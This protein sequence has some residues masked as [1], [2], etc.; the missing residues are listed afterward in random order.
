MTTEY[1]ETRMIN[2][3]LLQPYPGNAR[4]GDRKVLLESLEANGQYRSLVVRDDRDGS[5]DLIVL[6]GN[7]TLAALE[8]RGDL[9]AR[10]EIITCDDATAL[11]VNLVDNASNDKAS[12]DDRA[13]AQLIDLL[14]GGISGSGYDEDEADSILARFEE[15]EITELREP[16]VHYND[17]EE[18]R[19]TRVRNHG[20]ENS[21]TYESRGVRD[22]FLALPAADADEL[23]RLIMKL[24]ESWGALDQGTVILRAARVAA[25]VAVQDPAKVESADWFMGS[26]DVVY[27]PE[28]AD[29]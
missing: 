6:A 11:R 23:G 25:G 15:P 29:D 2:L 18:E 27:A 16:E 10:C 3:D 12:Y 28:Q 21:Q 14:D 4:Q 19:A 1:V 26:A 8:E 22:I 17:D 13:R 7:N 9:E 5:G 20:G 24:R